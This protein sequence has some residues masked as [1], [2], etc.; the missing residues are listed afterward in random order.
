MVIHKCI[1]FVVGLLFSIEVNAQFNTLHS[2]KEYKK[3]EVIENQVTEKKENPKY[4]KGFWGLFKSSK[5]KMKAEIDSLK[6][7]IQSKEQEQINFK[8]IE[9][10][11]IKS[12]TTKIKINADKK[13]IKTP[14]KIMPLKGNLKITSDFGERIHPIFQKQQMHNGVDFKANYELIYAVLDGV[15]S[16]AGWDNNGGGNYIKIKHS[17][18][19]ETSYLHL[20]EIYYKTEEKIKAGFIIGRSGN[21]GGSTAPHLHFAVKEND[22]Y[23]NPIDFLK[24]I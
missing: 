11:I 17:D 15:V 19:L 24:S 12:I 1:I 21:T 23:I 22:K 18:N 4:K 10:T 5:K 14:Q 8:K 3:Y 9:D 13:M 7:I 20:S 6:Q 2:K 16:E